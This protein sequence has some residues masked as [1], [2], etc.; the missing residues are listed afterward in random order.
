MQYKFLMLLCLVNFLFPIRGQNIWEYRSNMSPQILE[1]SSLNKLKI[2]AL[3]N[4]NQLFIST[5]SCRTWSL[6][7]SKVVRKFCLDKMGNIFILTNKIEMSSDQGETWHYWSN[8]LPTTE[9]P[10]S[11]CAG[12]NGTLFYSTYKDGLLIS[13]NFG[14]SWT[15]TSLKYDTP[16]L[17]IELNN[18]LFAFI[19]HGPI[20]HSMNRGETWKIIKRSIGYTGVEKLIADPSGNLYISCPPSIIDSTTIKLSEDFGVT[21]L[22]IASIPN[23]NLI[24]SLDSNVVFVSSYQSG[25]IWKLWKGSS[26]WEKENLSEGLPERLILDGFLGSDRKLYLLFENGEIFRTI[27]SLDNN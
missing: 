23:A 12:Y 26:G 9:I 25:L 10:N 20:F 17:V 13:E 21:W 4:N 16:Q 22:G 18:Y 14:E 2:L 3:A 15:S 1:I 19:L 8:E 5:D 7:T 6:F 24:F 27:Y 11:F